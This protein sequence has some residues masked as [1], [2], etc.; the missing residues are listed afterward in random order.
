MAWE[1][2]NTQTYIIFLN[3][4]SLCSKEELK[5]YK[6]LYVYNLVILSLGEVSLLLA[7]VKH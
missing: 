5:A 1:K 4:L 6:S 3:T 7:D 2:L